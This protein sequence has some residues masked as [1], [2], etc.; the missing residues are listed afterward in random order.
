MKVFNKSPKTFSEQLEIL[1][2]RGML[3]AD[4]QKA[5]FHLAQV[6]YYRLGA[7]WLDVC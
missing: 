3:V 4:E 7:Y 2:S 5:I 1:K 6:N